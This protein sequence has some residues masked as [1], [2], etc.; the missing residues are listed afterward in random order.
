VISDHFP[1]TNLLLVTTKLK[2]LIAS[3]CNARLA[4]L[5]SSRHGW[6]FALVSG[7]KKKEEMNH[8]EAPTSRSKPPVCVINPNQLV[9]DFSGSQMVAPEAKPIAGRPHAN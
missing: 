3:M 6:Q 8:L 7:S 2:R 5:A 1:I 9:I 4:P